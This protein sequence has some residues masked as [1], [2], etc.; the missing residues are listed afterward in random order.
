[1]ATEVCGGGTSDL[2]YVLGFSGIIRGG[3]IGF[4]SG[5][6]TGGARGRGR[7]L[8]PSGSLGP[9]L[10]YL[11]VPVFFIFSENIVRKFSA[12]SENFY[13]CTRNDTMV[14]LLKTASAWVSSNQIIPKSYKVM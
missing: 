6:P 14:V 11:F 9:P 2:S 8:H 5:G 13:F 1:M 10:R 3:G 12:H 7:A 4:T